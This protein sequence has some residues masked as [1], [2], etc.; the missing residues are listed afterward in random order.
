MNIFAVSVALF[1]LCNLATFL[2][3]LPSNLMAEKRDARRE[4]SATNKTTLLTVADSSV[5]QKNA[6]L[7]PKLNHKMAA[8]RRTS[9]GQK[10]SMFLNIEVFSTTSMK[11]YRCFMRAIY[12]R[13]SMFCY[14]MLAVFS[15]THA[16]SQSLANA[17]PIGFFAAQ[18]TCKEQRQSITKI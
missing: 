6:P 3:S 14:S 12:R 8:R 10:I 9:G 18:S 16:Q 1:T 11:T 7:V 5:E 15:S 2:L 17:N 13:L 4:S